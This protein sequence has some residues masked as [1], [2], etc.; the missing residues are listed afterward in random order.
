MLALARK[1]QGRWPHRLRPV[2]GACDRGPLAERMDTHNADYGLSRNFAGLRPA[3]LLASF[4]SCAG[5]WIIYG[6]RQENLAFS[7]IASAVFIGCVLA[8]IVIKDYVRHTARHYADSF[9]GALHS[10]DEA[11]Q[12]KSRKKGGAPSA[13][14]LPTEP[15]VI[16]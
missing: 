2:A 6:V 8:A 1:A 15:P 10:C 7:V 14:T 5:C 12:A 9:F 16:T 13:P 4:A 3:W 11:H